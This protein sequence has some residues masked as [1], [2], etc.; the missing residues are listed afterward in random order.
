MATRARKVAQA[1][2]AAAGARKRKADALE[3]ERIEFMKRFDATVKAV[4]ARHERD[5]AT[6]NKIIQGDSGWRKEGKAIS[7]SEDDLYP[8][9]QVETNDCVIKARKK[10]CDWLGTKPTIGGFV[11]YVPNGKLVW[12]TMAGKGVCAF[13]ALL[14]ASLFD[15]GALLHMCVC[16]ILF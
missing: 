8:E 2:A 9:D 13:E 16:M 5:T 15:E 6:K 14:C 3:Y 12:K 7:G 4:G 1:K 11:P 10:L